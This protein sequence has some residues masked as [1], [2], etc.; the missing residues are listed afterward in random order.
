M[1]KLRTFSVS[2]R[3]LDLYP[4]SDLAIDEYDAEGLYPYQQEVQERFSTS[5]NQ[6]RT[7][8]QKHRVIDKTR[9]RSG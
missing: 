1:G 6:V 3:T 8:Q 5:D 9:R 7:N 2:A 4:G